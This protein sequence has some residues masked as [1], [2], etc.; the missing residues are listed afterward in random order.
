MV[1]FVR[2]HDVVSVLSNRKNLA[3][4]PGISIKPDLSPAQRKAESILLKERRS[5]INSGVA[6]EDI[7]IKGNALLVNKAKYGHAVGDAFQRNPISVAGTA[8]NT[9]S[10]IG[11][12]PNSGPVESSIVTAPGDNPPCVNTQGNNL[13]SS[14]PTLLTPS[15]SSPKQVPIDPPTD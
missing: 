1:K 13:S 14:D 12:T 6:K 2:S 3:S 10:P 9:E 4:H 15:S 7:K 5:L 8:V 11:A